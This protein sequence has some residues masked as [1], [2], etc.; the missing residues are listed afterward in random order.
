MYKRQT[1]AIPNGNAKTTAAV[2][3]ERAVEVSFIEID[4]SSRRAVA[5]R[6]RVI[7]REIAMQMIGIFP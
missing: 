4:L 2:K 1:G 7:R 6:V 3:T 5:R